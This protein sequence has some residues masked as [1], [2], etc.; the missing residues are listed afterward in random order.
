MT[1]NSHVIESKDNI[2][3]CW[4]MLRHRTC[5]DTVLSCLCPKVFEG[6]LVPDVVSITL[7]AWGEGWASATYSLKSV[8]QSPMSSWACTELFPGSHSPSLL[9]TVQHNARLYIYENSH[10]WKVRGWSYDHQFFHNSLSTADWLRQ[11]IGISLNI[12]Q[13]GLWN[14]V[15][16]IFFLVNLSMIMSLGIAHHSINI[17]K[18]HLSLPECDISRSLD[19]LIIFYE[20]PQVKDAQWGNPLFF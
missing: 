7:V 17:A 3:S 16:V 2:G 18:Y 4:Y 6:T 10:N 9:E 11:Y 8:S 5:E 15:D 19:H 1:T 14:H 13:S 20:D 12:N